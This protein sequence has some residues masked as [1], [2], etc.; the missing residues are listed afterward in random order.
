MGSHG[1]SSRSV[2]QVYRG[3]LNPF[4]FLQRGFHMLLASGATHPLNVVGVLHFPLFLIFLIDDHTTVPVIGNIKIS[5]IDQDIRR[6]GHP[7]S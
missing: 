4:N 3:R 7:L 6:F 2:S 5:F 1:H